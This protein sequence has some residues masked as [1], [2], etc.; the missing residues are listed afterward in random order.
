[1]IDPT[2]LVHRE[3]RRAR[4]RAFFGLPGKLVIIGLSS[5]LMSGWL[6]A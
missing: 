4:F 1:M 2:W 3:W 5:L 6:L